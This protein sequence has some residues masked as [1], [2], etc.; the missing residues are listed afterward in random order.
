MPVDAGGQKESS[1]Q[2]QTK[3]SE[4]AKRIPLKQNRRDGEKQTFEE[5]K[6]EM[7]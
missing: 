2:T 4:L 7:S 1:D 5:P 3:C 6:K